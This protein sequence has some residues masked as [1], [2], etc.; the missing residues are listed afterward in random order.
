MVDVL[1]RL[2]GLF[3]G[4][5]DEEA[6]PRRVQVSGSEL[7]AWVN[8]GRPVTILDVRDQKAFRQGHIKGAVLI[9]LG[10]LAKRTHELRRGRPI[11]VLGQT[12]SK[13]RQAARYLRTQD[14]EAMV[15][16]GGIEGWP[17]R[18]VH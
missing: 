4:H 5:T 6:P 10:D 15:L 12:P 3:G 17:G 14:F 1:G 13:A 7:M 8:A 2:K 16:E 11:A 9:P 18:I